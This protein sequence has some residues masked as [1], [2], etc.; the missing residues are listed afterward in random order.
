MNYWSPWRFAPAIRQMPTTRFMMII[1]TAKIESRPIVGNSPGPRNT[2]AI[3]ITSI[4][5]IDSVRISVP[6]GSPS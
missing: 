1:I 6:Y 2:E 5:T 3:R 4:D